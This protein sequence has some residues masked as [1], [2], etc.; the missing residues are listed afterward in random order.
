MNF[1]ALQLLFFAF[2]HPSTH[3]VAKP[4]QGFSKRG[5]AMPSPCTEPPLFELLC[6]SN[7]SQGLAIAYLSRAFP[8]QISSVPCRCRVSHNCSTPWLL[9]A[10][11]SHALAAPCLSRQRRCKA[12]RL[13]SELCR[14]ST[15]H[16]DALPLLH[17]SMQFLCATSQGSAIAMPL[18]AI[19]SCA[20]AKRTRAER[21]HCVQSRTS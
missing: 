16:V 18:S 15:S 3:F 13:D 9:I 1:F 2:A 11:P 10:L 4:L 8:L 12:Y 14:C 17:S 6:L 19:P 7:S 21:C 20:L 5:R